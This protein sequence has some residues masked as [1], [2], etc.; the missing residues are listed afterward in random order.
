MSDQTN[1]DSGS[2][3]AP[4]SQPT[5]GESDT[6][7][8]QNEFQQQTE[9]V[10]YGESVTDIFS[11]TDTKPLLVQTIAIFAALG[12]GFGVF[13]YFAVDT[14]L[15]TGSTAGSSD[16]SGVFGL[17]GGA[18][19][20]VVVVFVASLTGPVVSVTTSIR[21]NGMLAY[22]KDDLSYATGAVGAAAGQAV[23]L[24]VTIFLVTNPLP[25]EVSVGF[26]DFISLIILSVIVTGI[27]AAATMYALRTIADPDRPDE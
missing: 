5:G 7:P 26:G 27:V 4:D 25:S 6:A 1:T 17:L 18:I 3:P 13:G 21:T 19:A 10:Q 15:T 14:L 22:L 24:V 8:Q 2:E 16:G 9:H 11:R 20:A 23:L 12:V